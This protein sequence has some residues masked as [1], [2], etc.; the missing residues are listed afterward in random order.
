MVLEPIIPY[1]QIL[2]LLC[3]P[4]PPSGQRN[5]SYITKN[6]TI[7]TFKSSISKILNVLVMK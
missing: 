6:K 1:G 3:L 2:N 5:K 7:N 4:I